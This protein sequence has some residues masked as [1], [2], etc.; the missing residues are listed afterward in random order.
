MSQKQQAT[1][2]PEA[3]GT[4]GVLFQSMSA[5]V[6]AASVVTLLVVSI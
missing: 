5:V 6:P 1:L 3:L 2:D 4:A